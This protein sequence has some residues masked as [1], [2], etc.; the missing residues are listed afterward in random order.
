MRRGLKNSMKLLLFV[1][2]MYNTIL[3]SAQS[4]KDVPFYVELSFNMGGNNLY[5]SG[6]YLYKT[7]DGFDEPVFCLDFSNGPF[8]ID[9]GYFSKTA[10]TKTIKVSLYVPKKSFSE[11]YL[12]DSDFGYWVPIP[13]SPYYDYIYPTFDDLE[14]FKEFTIETNLKLDDNLKNYSGYE[15]ILWDGKTDPA[16]TNGKNLPVQDKV[17]VFVTDA[18][19]DEFL[20]DYS[21]YR[22]EIRNPLEETYRRVN[23]YIGRYLHKYTAKEKSV[24]CDIYFIS[25][26]PVKKAVPFLG[27]SCT[28]QWADYTKVKEGIEKAVQSLL[29]YSD[30]ALEAYQVFDNLAP[31]KD[32]VYHLSWEIKDLNGNFF[33][34]AKM[35]GDPVFL[36][37][38]LYVEGDGQETYNLGL[39]EYGGTGHASMGDY[40]PA[41]WGR[42]LPPRPLKPDEPNFYPDFTITN[43][44]VLTQYNCS[45]YAVIIP[46]TVRKIDDNVFTGCPAT[47]MIIGQDGLNIIGNN[48]FTDCTILSTVYLPKTVT[49]IGARAFAD[50]SLMEVRVEWRT[51]LSVP[52]DIF[53]GGVTM[54]C[55]LYVPIGT[56]ELYQK[57]DVWKN[58][59]TIV[60]YMPVSNETIKYIENQTIKANFSKG[61]LYISGLQYGQPLC[62]YNIAGQLIYKSI[63]KAETEQIP[64]N[65]NGVYIIATENQSIKVVIE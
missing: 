17:F 46:K 61:V 65:G 21:P 55:K 64:F 29:L 32:G 25:Q 43:D 3:V 40:S 47:S 31:D 51:P 63:A 12:I 53:E 8:S 45:K 56:K 49:S 38:G 16:F 44:G 23:R 59:R 50:C 41:I 35:T 30:D 48:A 58:F 2:A 18:E 24:V 26:L 13:G 22:D 62:I 9:I 57:A 15:T 37:I 4:K 10:E 1:L 52:D 19:T 11:A 33:D 14:K 39:P 42:I 27:N 5:G 20:M 6:N 54:D 36:D 28:W 60:E 34:I 7:I